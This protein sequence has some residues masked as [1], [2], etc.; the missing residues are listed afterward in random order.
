MRSA[1]GARSD[2]EPDPPNL[3]MVTDKAVVRQ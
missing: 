3:L 2:T 1:A